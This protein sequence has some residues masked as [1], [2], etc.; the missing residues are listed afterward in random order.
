LVAQQS[1]PST[2]VKY[3]DSV[4]SQTVAGRYS[5]SYLELK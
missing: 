3:A 5:S 1:S 2:L 4:R